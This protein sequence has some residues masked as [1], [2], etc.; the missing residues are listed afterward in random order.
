[1]AGLL[2]KRMPEIRRLAQ[3]HVE[4]KREMQGN[5]LAP[6]TA[7]GA[8]LDFAC[9]NGRWAMEV[10]AQFPAARV[11]G[12]DATLPAPILSLGN[13]ID[14]KPP[15]ADFLQANLLERLPFPDATFDFVHMRFVYTVIPTQAW[16]PLMVEL[17]RVTRPGGWIESLEPL[18]FA[19]HQKEGLTTII[20]WLGEWLRSRG[21][22][23]LAALKMPTMM[24][25]AGLEQ[26]TS[27]QIGQNAG[28]MQDEKEMILRRNN[29]LL[30]I[31]L[32]RDPLVA[33]GIVVAEEYERVAAIARAE[34]QYNPALNCFNTYVNVGRRP[35][36]P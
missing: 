20:G 22:E 17:I 32:L 7:P 4:L 15:N 34:I 30:L 1:M 10:A 3:Q 21:A 12:I 27:Y 26:F 33:A 19:V 13:G 29:G 8:I 16:E 14:Q 35:M 24:K 31:D 9:E 25:A 23:P 6:I 11:V 2:A 18:P 5:F 28:N 36:T